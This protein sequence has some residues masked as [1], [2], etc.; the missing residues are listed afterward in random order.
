MSL[1]RP[2]F[3]YD[4]FLLGQPHHPSIHPPA[5]NTRREPA[6]TGLL[7]HGI[8]LEII[9]WIYYGFAEVHEFN[10]QMKMKKK[11]KI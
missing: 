5:Q 1:I 3:N 8:L 10:F 4:S 9:A 2:R 6:K 11:D 7:C